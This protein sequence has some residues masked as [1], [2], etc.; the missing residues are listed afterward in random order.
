MKLSIII[1]CYNEE[2]T[3]EEIIYKIN[4][5][6]DIDKEIIVVDDFSS[7]NTRTILET[8]LKDKINHL[9]LN[10]KNEGL[11]ERELKKLLVILY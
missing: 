1:P 5:Q 7:D 10:N 8:I 6:T 9:I 3:I 4:L 11:L 2:A